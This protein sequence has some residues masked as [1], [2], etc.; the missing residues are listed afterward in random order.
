MSKEDV[1][2]AEGEVVEV[3]GNMNFKVQIMNNHIIIAHISGKLR[4]NSIRIL[5]GDQNPKERKKM[6]EFYWEGIPPKSTF[7]QRD[8]N[9][10]KTPQA[11]LAFAQ[12]QAILEQG[13]PEHPLE[14]PLKFKLVLTWPFPK[15][16]KDTVVV[17][18]TTRPDGVNILKGV[19]DIMT[20]LG[21]WK[22]DNQLSIEIVE[23]WYGMYPGV[24][25]QISKVGEVAND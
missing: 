20:L 4:M 8:K 25:V 7:Q 23:R 6:V 16:R 19:E 10:H 11:R 2:E 1:I 22:D 15:R 17:P 14:G 5:V 13:V 3:L 24:L 9:F 21:Y 18:K 12:W